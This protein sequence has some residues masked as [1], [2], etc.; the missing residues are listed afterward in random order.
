MRNNLNAESNIA[1]LLS[2]WRKSELPIIH[3]QLCSAEPDSLLRL[4]LTGNAFKKE[5]LV[6]DL[7]K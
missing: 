2:A 5:A 6:A 1:L 3:I 7:E 4:E